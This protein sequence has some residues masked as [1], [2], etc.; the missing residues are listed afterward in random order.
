MPHSNRHTL[1]ILFLFSFDINLT[2]NVFLPVGI[3][4]LYSHNQTKEQL[5]AVFNQINGIIFPGGGSE[6]VRTPIFYA[7][8]YLYHLAL[9][10]ND[11]GVHFP[12]FG[13]CMGFQ[14]LSMIQSEDF[15]ILEA[16]EVEDQ[17]IPLN[18]TSL[19]HTSRIWGNAPAWVM[20][21]LATEP[22]TMNY[23]HWGVGLQRFQQNAKLNNF[24]DILSTNVDDHGRTF[25]STVQGKK[26]P[27]YGYQ[28]H[29]EKNAFE[30]SGHINHSPE[31]IA[32]MQYMAD[33]AVTEAR[34]N[35]Q[36]FANP[37]NEFDSLIYNYCPRYTAAIST[38]F[39]QSYV[40]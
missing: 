18:F 31:A 25:V 30:W 8:Q 26:Y 35:H 34:K 7:G 13:H 38:S 6:L 2:L 36:S 19:A 12:I 24:F 1:P 32:V 4:V 5:N 15:D 17:G 21:T 37:K 3:D 29:P 10:A 11:R 22:I 16:E 40:F 14:L 33:F 23:H 9:Q 27:I 20:K 39:V 28:W